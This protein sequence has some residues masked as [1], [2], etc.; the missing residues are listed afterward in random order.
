MSKIVLAARQQVAPL[1]RSSAVAALL[2][3][4][5]ATASAQMTSATDKMTP[6]GLAPG[7]PAGSYALSGFD[8]INLFNGNLNFR[9]PLVT[10]GGRGEASFTMMLALNDKNWRVK[11]EQS[12][13]NEP[14]TTYIPT[15]N[16]WNG[17]EVGYGPGVLQG[18]QS[19]VDA[20]YCVPAGH[21][22]G[23]ATNVIFKYSLT[24]LTFKT[25]DGTEFELVDQ[26]TLGKP[27]FVTA[28]ICSSTTGT[29]GEP[30]GSVFTT[31]D[32]TAATFVS[33]AP[34]YDKVMAPKLGDG[35]M[36]IYPSGY[37]T[38]RNGLRYRIE[39]GRISWMRDRNG[40]RISF[41]TG[42]AFATDSLNRQVRVEYN[43]TDPVCVGCNKII[44]KGFAGAERAIYVQGKYLSDAGVLRTGYSVQTYYNLFNL[45]GASTVN[46]YNP[47]VV[48]AVILPNGQSY[49]F[50]YNSYGELARVDLPTGGAIE[51][52]M[53]AGSG[54]LAGGSLG[55]EYQI[56]RRV[57]ERR[58][59]ENGV[60]LTSRTTYTLS[61]STVIEDQLTPTGTVLAR[62]KHY[63]IGDAAQSLFDKERGDIFNA[64]DEGKESA[65][66]AIDPATGVVLRRESNVWA[67]R[68]SI[69][70]FSW[71]QSEHGLSIGEPANDPRLTQT[72]STLV[73]TNQISKQTYLYDQFNNRTD[74]YAYDYGTGAV[75][76]LVRH[77]HTDYLAT[78]PI[79]NVDYTAIGIHLRGLPT[80]E[81]VFDAAE[82][83]KARVTYEY[84][85]YTADATHA[86]LLDRPGIIG[87]DS[88]YTSANQ[89]RGNVTRTSNWLLPGNQ[90]VSSYAQ[91]DV[92]GNGIR[93]I[94]ARG[95]ATA[96]DYTDRYG[97]PDGEARSNYSPVELNGYGFSYA[98]PTSA[99]NALGHTVYAQYDY[100]LGRVVDGEDA[101]GITSSAYYM[102][103]LD[104]PTQV[105]RAANTSVNAGVKSQ[106]AFNYND[107]LRVITTTSDQN[108]YGDNLL[109]SEAWFDGL[110]RSFE[111]RQYESANNY[112]ATRQNYDTL[113]RISQS[114]NP[115]RAGETVLWTT[116]QYD[117]LS[118]QTSV[119]TPDNAV[120]LTS[121][122]G[123]QVT[124]TDQAGKARRSATDALGRLTSVW[125]DPSGLNYLTT[126]TYDVLG[127]LSGVTQ[128]AQTRSF[129]YDSLSRLILA[130][131]PEQAGTLTDSRA[132]GL[133]S[134]SY[135]Y[136]GNGN[137]TQKTDARGV[138]TGY[139]YDALN[140]PASR[141]YSDST[142]AVTYSYDAAWIANSKGRLVSV[143]SSVSATN[144]T[145]FDALGRTTA[146]QQITDSQTYTLGYTYNVAGSLISEVYPSG[147]TIST[148]YDG[149]GR[150]ASV[151]GQ[152]SGEAQK[153]YASAISYTPHGA[154]AALNLGNGLSEQTVFNSRL[155]PQMIKLKT[156]AN[157]SVE[158]MHYY[159]GGAENNGNV[160]HHA[161]VVEGLARQQVFE[162]DQLNRLKKASE[163]NQ[164]SGVQHWQQSF[165]Y[166][167]YGNR[168][169]NVGQT[170]PAMLGSN[171]T[172]DQNSNRYA[173]GQGSILYD[174]AGNLTRD[175]QGH[176]FSYDAEG[177]QLNYD[178][179]AATSASYAYDGDGR[180][181]KKIVGNVA[182]I[183]IYDIKGQLVAEY[184]PTSPQG[185]IQTSY[186]TSDSLGT[187]RVITDSSGTVKARHDY[188]PFGEEIGAGIG[189]RTPAQGYIADNVRQKF[190]SHERDIETGL[191][192]VEARYYASIQGRF[193][194]P[195]PLLS[196]G[197]VKDPQTWNRY[198]Y[199]LNN[200][201][202]F[203]DPFGLY[204]FDK[205]VTEAQ[206]KQF[207]AGLEQARQNL[208]KI[209][210][211]YGTDSN[212]YKKAEAALNS[213][214]D[215]GVDNGVKIFAA[216]GGGAGRV[217]VKG[218]AGRKTDDNPTGQRIKVSFDADVFDNESF[219]DL[220]GHEGAHVADGSNW[221][222]S[223]F[224]DSAHP[225]SYQ[226]ESDGFLVQSLLAQARNPDR[227]SYIPLPGFKAPGKNPYLPQE[228][229]IW[230][231]S[232]AEADRATLRRTNIDKILS[233]P[234]SAGGM[235]GLTPS[236]TDK[237]FK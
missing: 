184:A 53:T 195:D 104:R 229:D 142:P 205:N 16:P 45:N 152:K 43:T 114:S 236:S 74:V 150:V 69:P 193:T 73:D 129:F 58:T 153:T 137:L 216:E 28:S 34:I 6:S 72:V 87:Q 164:A 143:S 169:F 190:A 126:Y 187:P 56:Y 64:W 183:Y 29:Q 189:A 221:V 52:D 90:T 63:F 151:S 59:Y 220:I 2:W 11:R 108:V 175:F 198:S 165:T 156:S 97:P 191:D 113:G 134:I 115:Y 218:T 177:K 161:T 37:L 168:N 89:T 40:N 208:Q 173:A 1:I 46:N 81:S 54:V 25:P 100:Y 192:F 110:G 121:Y 23:D 65:T 50:K 146:S 212:E 136:D 232:W 131:N 202:K 21:N 30:R 85:N 94:D 199:A 106:T 214:G 117:A 75:G 36:L 91:Y 217:E 194:S 196:S 171:L 182:T 103:A 70:W 8:N 162:Y 98:L 203:T 57:A 80:Q 99:T 12:H 7:S 138:T 82:V 219:G 96:L 157:Q 200:P 67:Q 201:L 109:K 227:R 39:H 77:T 66:E 176:T 31:R 124:V 185:N 27:L 68:A 15:P 48:S 166:D 10:M 111:T 93:L 231:P 233:R 125:E 84:D 9:L 207:N 235:Y 186:L 76:P 180:R 95:Y 230:N 145:A 206:R 71:W 222:K 188:L 123:N 119:T 17:L 234:K 132:A 140:R 133:W 18:R 35:L 62:T 228:I 130:R 4:L 78:N 181:V 159:Y 33:D 38:L 172:V 60:T 158:E 83:E 128:G 3:L 204:I 51:Y 139:N 147:R 135:L 14:V 105:V 148:A 225:T 167:R 237:A 5:A 154:T 170:T 26:P 226:T 118:R 210:E 179:G 107:A 49:Q 127:N 178:F 86:P 88:G 211:T 209:G 102:D 24:T 116:T 215:E 112:I 79:N 92:A 141:T 55:D 144:Y 122:S 224:A 160:L 163:V 32:G 213:Y 155:Q 42:G 44:L 61:G 223:G 22:I 174:E 20:Q 197:T 41:G 101:N 47:V 120:F 149:A 13:T 19:G